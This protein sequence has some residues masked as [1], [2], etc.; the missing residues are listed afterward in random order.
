[1][2]TS[3]AVLPTD[4]M[5]KKSLR[6]S[7]ERRQPLT[8]IKQAMVEQAVDCVVDPNLHDVQK[9]CEKV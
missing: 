1:M 6:H 9:F 5:K 3:A 4:R 8:G 2:S 7:W